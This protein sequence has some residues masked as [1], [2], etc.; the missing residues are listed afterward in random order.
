M[1]NSGV[2]GVPGVQFVAFPVRVM[3]VVEVCRTVDVETYSN[4][5]LFSIIIVLEEEVAVLPLPSFATAIS[6]YVP[7]ATVVES[8]LNVLGEVVP[9]EVPTK[10]VPM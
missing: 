3:V 9:V 8:Q 10:V 1:V 7:S 6:A 2:P 5:T 4:G